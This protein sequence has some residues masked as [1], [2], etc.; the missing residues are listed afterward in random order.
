MRKVQQINIEYAWIVGITPKT[1]LE[2]L[3]CLRDHR[4]LPKE[5][6]ERILKNW[7][8]HTD[9]HTTEMSSD[10]ESEHGYIVISQE[11]PVYNDSTITDEPLVQQTDEISN[12]D[13]EN[14]HLLQTLLTVPMKTNLQKEAL[15]NRKQMMKAYKK[16][17]DM[18]TS[19]HTDEIEN[20]NPVRRSTRERR[21]PAWLRSGEFDICKSAIST[22]ADWEKK[23]SCILNLATNS[24]IFQTLQAESGQA[25]LSI[26]ST[27]NTQS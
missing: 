12:T 9:E 4:F 13:D 14:A 23:V 11:E 16:T 8:T 18:N 27:S 20:L 5:P 6:F 21:Q 24:P 7:N 26:L 2:S 17:L 22:T 25:I 10:D 19:Q 15:H 1:E 3:L